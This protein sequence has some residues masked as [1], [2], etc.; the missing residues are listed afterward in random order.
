MKIKNTSKVQCESG[1]QE[2]TYLSEYQDISC[3]AASNRSSTFM[4]GYH[5]R[6]KE[7]RGKQSKAYLVNVRMIYFCQEPNLEE[8]RHD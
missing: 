7:K 3:Q 6:R 1:G 4:K 5:Q 2:S 8:A